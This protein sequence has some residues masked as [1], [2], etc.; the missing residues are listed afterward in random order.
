MGGSWEIGVGICLLFTTGVEGGT[1]RVRRD[2][3]S[4]SKSRIGAG[5]VGS[6]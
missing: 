2:V 5:F 4:E 1:Q 3:G 6:D